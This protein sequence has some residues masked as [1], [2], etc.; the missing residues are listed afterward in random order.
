MACSGTE[1]RRIIPDEG[2]ASQNP[3]SVKKLIFCSGKVYFDLVKATRELGLDDKIAI[4]RVE[5]VKRWE[6]FSIKEIDITDLFVSVN[7]FPIRSDQERMRKVLERPNRL[8]SG[9][10]QEPRRLD[11][12]QAQIRNHFGRSTRCNVSGYFAIYFAARCTIA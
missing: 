1:F 9:R 7:S 8:G 11:L 12:C 10:A 5:Q 3:G 2:K 4:T 6:L